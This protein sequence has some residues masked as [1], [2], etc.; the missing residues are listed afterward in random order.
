[1]GA[2]LFP[3]KY[4]ADVML[5]RTARWLRMLGCDVFYQANIDDDELLFKSLLENRI[6]LTR[7][8]KLSFRGGSAAY[9]VRANGLWNELREILN[10]F[11]IEPKLC[12]IRCPICNGEIEPV[13]KSTIEEEVPKYTFLTHEKFWR[14]KNCGKIFWQ[15]THSKMAEKDI[16][17]KIIGGTD[18]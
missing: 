1:M 3:K 7:D 12:L 18:F 17:K 4:S 13:E 14:C 11:A 15:G 10:H 2:N 16:F 9:L 8:V 6:L 5:G